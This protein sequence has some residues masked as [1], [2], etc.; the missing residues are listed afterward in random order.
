M[1]IQAS[2]AASTH[3]SPAPASVP[4]GGFLQ[5]PLERY[6]NQA[7][8]VWF[9]G[10]WLG[11]F[12]SAEAKLHDMIRSFNQGGWRVVQVIPASQTNILATIG[13]YIVLCC[14]F[15]LYTRSGG[16]IVVFERRVQ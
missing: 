9:S 12:S 4:H 10:G 8:R 13:W 11:L 1:T 7:V 16:L 14:T 6:E 2:L 3:Q 5:G 15:G